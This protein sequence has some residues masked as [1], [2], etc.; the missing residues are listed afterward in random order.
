MRYWM[1]IGEGGED[2]LSL[3][4]PKKKPEGETPKAGNQAAKPA[5]E[6]PTAGAQAKKPTSD[7]PK[8]EFRGFLA[9]DLSFTI[10][11]DGEEEF[12][13]L[14]E[15]VL[16][17]DVFLL[18]GHYSE[19]FEA[20]SRRLT[21]VGA[22]SIND[23]EGKRIACSKLLSGIVFEKAGIPQ[24][25]T[26]LIGKGTGA[27]TVEGIFG[28]PVIL[29][30]SD[31]AQGKGVSLLENREALE[32]KLS[33]I[34]SLM[35]N[36][37]APWLAQE[38]IAAS[39]GRDIRVE[40]AEYKVIDVLARV[41][42]DPNEFRS[43]VHLGGHVE[44]WELSEEAKEM[45]ERAARAVG[46]RLCG[47]DLLL[48]GDGGYVVGEINCTPGMRDEYMKSPQFQKDMNALLM[49]TLKG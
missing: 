20:I 10:G 11:K 31:G 27:D 33:E 32:T 45:C 44:D 34:Q 22:K 17:P 35:A 47:I 39:R 41:A 15:K 38:Y 2:M 18:W 37:G 30:P 14:G 24:P 26:L 6:K 25:K 1:I 4:K 13:I 43:N 16:P 9:D 3:V 36:G 40:V 5:G 29:K 48:T 7:K 21:S 49:N 8:L 19:Q 42:A 23:I 46:L 12:Y 28:Y